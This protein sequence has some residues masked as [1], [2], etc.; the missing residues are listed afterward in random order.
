M[1]DL[2]LPGEVS[3][4]LLFSLPIPLLLLIAICLLLRSQLEQLTFSIRGALGFC[5][6][7]I[8]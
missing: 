6:R 4:T 5:T 2:L 3:K 1:L 8:P 7:L